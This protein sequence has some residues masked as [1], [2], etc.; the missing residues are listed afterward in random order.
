[1]RE[2][3]I[4]IV[5]KVLKKYLPQ[6]K[7]QLESVPD[8][9]GQDHSEFSHKTGVI[10]LPLLNLNENCEQDAIKILDFYIELVQE[11][12]RKIK[13]P[14]QI[15]GDQLTTDRFDTSGN[16]RLGNLHKCFANFR[17]T[18]FKVFHLGMNFLD[19]IIFEPL[20]SSERK[21]NLVPF[22]E[23]TVSLL[24]KMCQK[25]MRLIRTIL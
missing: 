17:P 5:A 15:G 3:M 2:T 9:F 19:R 14:I 1:M 25:P 20:W 6:L 8:N 10:P 21:R 11:L 22:R 4:M 13:E 18:T 24:I 16:L 7:F 23:K 12:P